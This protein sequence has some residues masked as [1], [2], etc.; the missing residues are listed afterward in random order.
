MSKAQRKPRPSAPD[1]AYYDDQCCLCKHENG[2]N[3]CKLNK[4]TNADIK[5]KRD[6][7]TKQKLR[8]LTA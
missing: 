4:I 2:C 7:L 5:K 8:Q 6:R 1:W 3:N